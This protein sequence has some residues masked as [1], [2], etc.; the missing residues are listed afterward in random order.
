VNGDRP[1]L[2]VI[3]G[4]SKKPRHAPRGFYRRAAW[5]GPNVTQIERRPEFVAE[6]RYD[7]GLTPDIE[8]D[9]A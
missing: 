5:L 9:E 4:E 6:L 8:V 7:L 2:R 3:R 1:I